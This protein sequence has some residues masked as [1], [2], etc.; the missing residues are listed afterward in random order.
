MLF[1]I[2]DDNTD[3]SRFPFVN[4]IF[5]AINIAVFVLLQGLGG[6]DAFTYAFSTV[7]REIL[8]GQDVQGVFPVTDMT[9]RVLGRI[10]LEETPIPVYGTILTSMFMHGGF[11]HIFG[12]MLYLW[13]FGDNLEDRLGH[14]RYAVFYLICGV[15]AA[16][17]Q[18]FVSSDSVIPMLGASGAISGVLGG[19]LLLFPRRNVKAI[20]FYNII[21]VP[22]YVA[23]GLWIAL[24][25][26]RGYFDTA[27]AGGVAYMAHIGGFVAG[28]LLIKIFA[29]GTQ[30]STTGQ[31]TER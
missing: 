5:I 3:L 6:N 29:I 31:N 17:A 25:V 9:G 24:Q 16:L 28:F 14:I 30:P 15:V 19:Y 4:Y 13:I 22:A 26:F 20:I 8:T 27:E 18:V 7:P 2:G 10:R 12:N 23:L 11:M 1:P 21:Y